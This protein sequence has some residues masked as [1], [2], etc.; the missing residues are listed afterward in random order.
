MATLPFNSTNVP[1]FD[2]KTQVKA[3]QPYLEDACRRVL[4]S[5]QAIGGPEVSALEQEVAD[6][7]GAAA[8]VACASGSDALSLCLAALDIG[9]GDEVILP[10]FT[11]FAS[12]GAVARCG[13]T[14]VFAD[15][16]ADTYNIDPH[17]VENK[18][19]PRTRAIMAVHLYGQCCDM[20]AL[21]RIAE[22]HNL[23]II[24]D[25]CQ[26]IG[27]D[28]QGK[29]AGTLGSMACFSF[30][31]T[32]NLGAYGDA[33]M[34]VTSD[35]DWADKMTALRNHGSH[36]R[37]YHELL[38]WNSR[39]DAL[40]AALLRVKLPYLDKWCDGRAAIAKRYDRLIDE[41]QLGHLFKKPVVRSYGRHTFHQYVVRVQNGLRDA[42]R[43]HLKKDSIGTEVYYPLCLH[44]QK[45]FLHL[46]YKAGDFP[47]SERA[48]SEVMALPMFPEL[49]LEQQKRV[50][51]SCG[52][53]IRSRLRLAA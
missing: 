26:A 14:P 25:A 18:I 46:G 15:I 12:A 4:L 32:K 3:L 33:G 42:L 2:A 49:S 11:F 10:P 21:W 34:V 9:P 24:E 31:P 47:V 48:A 6:Y 45:A 39:L 52:N 5:G 37:Y 53:F 19:T 51:Q 8:A 29:R 30:Y 41:H 7:C 1:L 22:R 20:E 28:Y 23:P 17:Q 43:D 36:Q 35:R 38:G 44:Q 27:A 16:E 13:A 40:Q 50:V